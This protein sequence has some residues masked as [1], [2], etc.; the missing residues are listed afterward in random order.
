MVFIVSRFG[1][2]HS[3]QA[4]R[5]GSEEPGSTMAAGV[6]SDPPYSTAGARSG[7][8]TSEMERDPPV[9]TRVPT[10][11]YT[12]VGETL[13]HVI[14]GHMQCSM[15]CG[16][17]ACKYENPSRWSDEEQA[18]KGL[19]SSWI[20]DNLLAMARPSTE[21]IEKYNIID[22]FQ[23]C[24]L[25][26]VINLQR[27]GEHASCGYPLEQESGFTYRPETFM[28]AGIYFYNFGWKDYGVASLTTILDMVK[29]M[30]FAIQE[31]KM[32]VHC[33]AG[34]GRT[35]VL[36]ACY[37]VFTTRMS[38]DQAILFMRAKRPNSIQTRG[39][40]LCVRE[41]AQFLVPLRN[42]FSCAEPKANPVTLSQYLTRQR[43]LLHGYEARQLK[44]TPKIVHV[45]CKLLLDIAENRQVIQEEV[46]EIPDLT[47]E[48]EKTVSQ[49][50]IQQ[51]GK[52]MI[53]KGISV[54][55]P[56]PPSLPKLPSVPANDAVLPSDHDLDPLWNRQ[57]GGRIKSG[58]CL[59]KS[60]SESDVHRVGVTWI[61]VDS[62]LAVQE[63]KPFTNTLS[64]Q[65]LSQNNLAEDHEP[66][67][68]I[69]S[70]VPLSHKQ[71]LLYSSTSSIW[72]Q[73]K[74]AHEKSESPLFHRRRP[75]KGGHRSLSLGCTERGEKVNSRAVV[76]AWQAERKAVAHQ[77]QSTGR[78]SPVEAPEFHTG[79]GNDEIDRSPEI[80]TFTLQAELPPDARRLRVAQA[81]A[82]EL[83]ED[84]EE[85]RQKVS[86]WQTE[87]NS[88]EGAWERMCTERDP[89]VLA[90][91][92][93]SWLEQLKEPI[94]TK[95]DV[96]ALDRNHQDL[97]L[98]L[99]SM[100]KGPKQTLVCIL[101]CVAH[102][103]TIPE[104]AEAAV[105]DRTIKAFTKMGSDSEEEITVH[106][107][108]KAI[109]KPV[110]HD[111]R[112]KAMEELETPCYCISVP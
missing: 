88:R 12:K 13:R 48:V 81:L 34:L 41:F 66:H 46:L 107:T 45:V 51:L 91:I 57:N 87:L 35:G 4:V 75:L 78:T 64:K 76:S 5:N 27:P 67:E 111:M 83:D 85:H 92:M 49:Q 82:V 21:I 30:S 69:P 98:A 43:H 36:L 65:C 62:P 93:W 10:A 86:S 33:H 32:A 74:A 95:E 18:I 6:L 68:A 102:L 96:Q 105:L 52:E 7:E 99:S 42:V 80:P 56:R 100:D 89:V 37:L 50:A 9:S 8:H 2:E 84:W 101:H 94:I 39:Q 44:N 73:S 106:R 17:R 23:R 63:A 25:R 19:Y 58:P 16:G 108:L 47:A 70:S 109:L 77:N 15:A 71:G 28:E 112:K 24:G 11:K 26:T 1:V 60:Y 104:E 22:Q 54:P 29:V 103:K 3:E 14:P 79:D 72:E 55:S 20:T 40:L 110:L 90:G 53:G 31:G 61:L 97:Q 59:R 38:A